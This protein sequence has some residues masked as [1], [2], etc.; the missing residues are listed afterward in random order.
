MTAVGAQGRR[1]SPRAC[2]KTA[3]AEDRLDRHGSDEIHGGERTWASRGFGGRRGDGCHVGQHGCRC[4]FG[5][6]DQ[7][8]LVG[9]ACQGKMILNFQNEFPFNAELDRNLKKYLETLKKYETFS[10]DRLE[11]LAQLLYWKP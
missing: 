7:I 2:A 5:L 1:G 9:L 11:Y 8:R 3:G 6:A 4:V 10:G